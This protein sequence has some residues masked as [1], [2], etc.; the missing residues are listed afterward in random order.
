[1]ILLLKYLKNY[2]IKEGKN[3]SYA[4]LFLSKYIEINELI[5]E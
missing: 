1:M 2:Y 3:L 4:E 5:L